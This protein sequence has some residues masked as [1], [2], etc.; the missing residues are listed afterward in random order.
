MPSQ[1]QPI[2]NESPNEA[3]W[4]QALLDLDAEIAASTT[5]TEAEKHYL[6]VEMDQVAEEDWEPI[7]I[8][9]EPL[10]VSIINGRGER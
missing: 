9:G 3:L 4:A 10:S 6:L 7:T 2:L 5:L 8:E 1:A